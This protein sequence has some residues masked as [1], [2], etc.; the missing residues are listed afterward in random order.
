[1]EDFRLGLRIGLL[2]IFV[3][4]SAFFN[5]SETALFAANRVVLR[6]RRAQGDR[7]ARTAYA[8]LNQASELLT[9]LLAGVTMA[10]VGVSVVATS[11]ALS[12]VR[13]GG[14][15][16]AFLGTTAIVLILAEIAPK[17]LAAR[18]ADLRR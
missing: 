7:R 10:N 17:T 5:A 15:W 3:L 2:V 13:R 18:H 4:C 11:I 6:Q 14:E 16:V 9:T 12:L 8:L 1:M